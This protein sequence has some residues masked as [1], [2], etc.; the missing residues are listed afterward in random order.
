MPGPKQALSRGNAVTFVVN[1][2]GNITQVLVKFN[3]PDPTNDMDPS[4]N[5]A[6]LYGAP[7]RY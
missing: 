2:R 1:G 3:F 5:D 7:F 6:L 4:F